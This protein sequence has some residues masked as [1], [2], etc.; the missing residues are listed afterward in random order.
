MFAFFS[1]YN[2]IIC[3]RIAWHMLICW[4]DRTKNSYWSYEWM[5]VYSM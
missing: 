1:N 3:R 2:K 4:F 5:D